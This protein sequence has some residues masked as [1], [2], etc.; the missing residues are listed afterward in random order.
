MTQLIKVTRVTCKEQTQTTPQDSKGSPSYVHQ[1]CQHPLSAWAAERE[2]ETETD[3]H[4]QTYREG[5]R[6]GEGERDRDRQTDRSP[7]YVHILFLHELQ[8]VQYYG[9]AQQNWQGLHGQCGHQ[10]RQNTV[11]LPSWQ[12]V[13]DMSTASS[14]SR[15]SSFCTLSTEMWTRLASTASHGGSLAV[16]DHPF[17][18]CLQIDE[19]GLVSTASHGGSLAVDDHPFA[20]CLQIDEQGLVSTA[21]H[22]GSLAVDDHPFAHCLQIDEQGLASTASHGGSFKHAHTLT[23]TSLFFSTPTQTK[24]IMR[25]INTMTTQVISNLRYAQLGVFCASLKCQCLK[26]CALHL[27]RWKKMNH[28]VCSKI[29][30]HDWK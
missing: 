9:E 4:R 30:T 1:K 14:S 23:A 28:F 5:G 27:R 26:I 13:V 7:S 22:G 12:E 16:D 3:R 18:H 29:S 11:H 10:Q 20:H 19:Q 2:R 25:S 24:H 15:W 8:D 6:G 21:S 17:A